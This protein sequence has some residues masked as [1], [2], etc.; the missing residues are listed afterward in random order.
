MKKILFTLF[1]VLLVAFTTMAQWVNDPAQNTLLASGSNDYG[2]LYVSTNESN[3]NTYFQ[4]NNMKSN[5][6]SPSLQMV[7]VDGTPQWGSDGI[8]IMGQTFASYS[9]GIA[10][11]YLKGGG[12][13]SAFANENGQCIAV[14]IND[15]GTF[16]WGE[17]GI[18]ALDMIS[19][20]RTELAAGSDG[21]FWILAF[22]END[23]YLRY[24][25]ADG[26]PAGNQITI[27]D[28]GN[29]SIAFSQMVLDSSDNV[30]VVYEKQSWA[31]SY[32]Y[33][34]SIYVAKYSTA[35]TQLTPETLLMSEQMMSGQISHDVCADGLGGGYA[36]ISY[37][38]NECFEVFVFHFNSNGENTY[39]GTDGVV[40]SQQDGYNYH[41]QP[42]ASVD[43]ASHDLLVAYRQTDAQTQSQD[44][45]YLNRITATG[46]KPWG[47]AGITVLPISSSNIGELFVNTFDGGSVVTYAICDVPY[48]YMIKAKGFNDLGNSIWE[49]D[50]CTHVSNI[51]MCEN[52]SGFHNGQLIAAW[53]D[54]RSG[55]A[56]YG[57]NIHTDGTLGPQ[58]PTACNAPSYL[59]ASA[60]ADNAVLTWGESTT[61]Q[62][63]NI[64]RGGNLLANVTETT[65][66]DNGLDIL[67]QYCYTVT[68]VCSTSE[69]S[70]P[71]EEACVT[72]QAVMMN[73]TIYIATGGSMPEPG[74]LTIV[75]MTTS[76]LTVNEF[77]S[78][79]FAIICYEDA[80]MTTVVSSLTIPSEG[81]ATVY[82]VVDEILSKEIFTGTM[83]V[84]TSAGVYEV[85]IVLN[86]YEMI[87]E[88]EMQAVSLYPNPA[89]E[90]VTIS[91]ENLGMVSIFN[92]VGQKVEEFE[93]KDNTLIINTLSYE[94]GVY[95]VKING[96][97]TARFVVTH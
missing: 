28:T 75:N 85:T 77:S 2:E 14:K 69:E 82:V 68:S 74:A 64:Y 72:T 18:V 70:D 71:T 66:T 62:S 89:N 6:W 26:T 81:E 35:G 3:G 45:L 57:Q 27:S 4:W 76:D 29:K 7:D 80:E 95:F 11:T 8:A 10:M 94:N 60:G 42:S 44:A 13:V 46:S 38:L 34:K 9:N 91:G 53:E 25:N 5:G 54:Q 90:S 84:G 32:Y 79:D 19:C 49:A 40:L 59:T 12:V 73:D 83:R 39:N 61:A 56:L 48:Q 63:Y 24:Y 33:N 65:Y 47:G 97:K 36:W 21:G 22:N 86:Y 96:K 92:A 87:S 78:N 52:T 67:T 20:T 41:L 17:A 43:A 15:D 55:K 50:I 1:S 37:P 30:F 58:D 88:N 31:V 23:T 51:S 16:A 93:I